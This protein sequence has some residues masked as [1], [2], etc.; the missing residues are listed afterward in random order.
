V[1][2]ITEAQAAYRITIFGEGNV[3]K[4]TLCRRYL[5]GNYEYDTHATLGLAVH[6]K[7]MVIDEKKIT[8]QIWD[9][10]GEERFR[11]LLKNYS[12]GSWGGLFMFD[13]SNKA[14]LDRME[15]WLKIFREGL[16]EN[17]KDIPMYLIG[18]KSDLIDERQVS[19]E[20]ASEVA[21]TNGFNEYIECSSKTGENADLL[22][23][24]ITELIA[25][26]A[27]FL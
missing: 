12:R 20:E 9:F 24:K 13:L 22:F 2:T 17:K 19:F 23:D 3:G 16:L 15:G 25:T 5:T 14:S 11:F 8:L 27:G 10:G 6:V 26:K 7:Y 18:G 21:K 4:T 1:I